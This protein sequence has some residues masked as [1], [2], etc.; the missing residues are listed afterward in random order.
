MNNELTLHH[1]SNESFNEFV[2]AMFKCDLR[3]MNVYM[4]KVALNTFSYFDAGRKPSEENEPE[5][6]YHGFV[7][8]LLVDNAK[9]YVIKS[10]RE[11]R[12]GRYDVVLEPK[13]KMMSLSS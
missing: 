7:L 10:N 8:G 5:K 6:F 9:N 11:S 1:G 3:G 2:K 4:N 12:Y 13:K